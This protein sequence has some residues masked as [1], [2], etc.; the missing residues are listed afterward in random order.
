MDVSVHLWSSVV[1]RRLSHF[2]LHTRG[3]MSSLYCRYFSQ[4][5]I[6]FLFLQPWRISWGTHLRTNLS[7]WFCL[8]RYVGI[9]FPNSVPPLLFWSLERSGVGKT[10]VIPRQSCC[11]TQCWIRTSCHVQIQHC[12][13]LLC[14]PKIWSLKFKSFN[15]VAPFLTLIRYLPQKSYIFGFPHLLKTFPFILKSCPVC[16]FTFKFRF[17]SGS[18]Y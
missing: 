17:L 18:Y 15:S 5:V 3:C 9:F 4:S 2:L 11:S 13:K 1:C 8:S 10:F 12:F 16:G 14:T 7:W 6:T